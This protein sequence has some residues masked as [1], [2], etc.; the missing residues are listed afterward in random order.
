[1]NKQFNGSIEW[2]GIVYIGALYGT[3]QVMCAL[4]GFNFGNIVCFVRF[5]E[6]NDLDLVN[7]SMFKW[8][9]AIETTATARISTHKRPYTISYRIKS[10]SCWIY[11]WNVKQLQQYT[12]LPYAHYPTETPKRVL[13]KRIHKI[14]SFLSLHL[15]AY[16]VSS[17][18]PFILCMQWILR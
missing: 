4:F 11:R 18:D 14:N 16:V 8:W 7:V 2:I 15:T 10:S 9:D 1:M 13:I 3:L 12:I 5:W 17:M 6:W